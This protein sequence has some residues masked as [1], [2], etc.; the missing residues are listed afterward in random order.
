MVTIDET[1]RLKQGETYEFAFKGLSTDTKPIGTYNGLSIANGSTFI[2]MDTK[3]FKYY[4][5]GGGT[6]V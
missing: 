2:E 4:D 6:W 1:P 5:E 3:I